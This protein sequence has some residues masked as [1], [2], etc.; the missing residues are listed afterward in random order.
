VETPVTRQPLNADIPAHVPAYLV[1]NIS[2]HNAPGVDRDP[3]AVLDSLRDGRDI[4]WGLGARRGKDAWIIKSY[5]LLLEAYQS[6][7]LFSSERFS[8]FS[9]LLDEDWLLTPVEVDAPLHTAYRKFLNQFFTP[10]RMKEMEPSIRAMVRELTNAV[11]P[12]RACEF[13]QSIAT[14]LPTTVFLTMFGLPLADAPLFLEWEAALM[15]SI[16][17]RETARGGRAIR[18][19]MVDAIKDRQAHPRQDL[20][21]YFSNAVID[22]RELEPNE[23]LGMC[24]NIYI[25]GLDTVTNGLGT[26]FIYLAETPDQQAFLRAN[27]DCRAKAIEEIL[28]ARSN[29]VNGRF[30]AKDMIFHGVEMKRGDRVAIPTMFANRDAQQF[31]NPGAIDFDRKNTMS[32]IVFGS[33]IHNCLGAHLARREIKIVVD[34]WL[35]GVPPFRIP[36]REAAVTFAS[37]AVFGVDRLPLEW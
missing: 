25:A 8:G 3:A 22:G 19:Y 31:Q 7:H 26:T 17:D 36:E 18:D 20:M 33:G 12:S 6:P 32:H 10:S 16:D 11:L 15:H 27:P 34:E 23:K 35:D 9:K 37:S 13:Q 4:V 21:S 5:K 28:R 24:F 2:F 29:V 30:V 1:Q 14:P